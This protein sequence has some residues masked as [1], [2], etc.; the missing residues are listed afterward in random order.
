MLFISDHLSS[1]CQ[2]V[3]I[4]PGYRTDHT[5]LAMELRAIESRGPGLWKFN[6]SLLNDDDKNFEAV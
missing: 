1:T 2:D 3:S 6:E 5:M 4:N